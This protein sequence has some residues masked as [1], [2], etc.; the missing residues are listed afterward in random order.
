M[1]FRPYNTNQTKF[2]NLDYRKLLGEDSDAVII[3]NIV[4]VL[5]LSEFELKYVE[6]GNPAYNPRMMMKIIIYG[7]VKSYFGGRP[8]YNNFENDLGLRFLSNDDFPDYR[9]INLFRVNFREEI[10]D[11]FAQ[12]VMLCKELDMIGFENL[13]IDGQK[14]KANANVFQNKNLKSIRKEKERIEIQLKKLLENELDFRQ[15]NEN[16][17][18]ISKKRE[19]LKRRKRRLDIAAQLLIDAGAENDDE[20]RYNLTDPDSRIMTDKRGVKNPDYNAQNAVDDKFQVLTAVDVTDTPSDNEELF[21]MKEKSKE[22]AGRNHENTLAD[23]GYGNKVKFG[24]MEQD[25][26]TE[27]Y[28][29]DKTMYSSKKNPFSKWNFKKDP[30]RDDV[31]ICPEGKEMIYQRTSKDNKGLPYR[32]Y[33][34]MDCSNCE[35]RDKCLRTSKKGRLKKVVK[36]NRKIAIYPEDQYVKKMREKLETDEGKK[37]YQRRMS[38]VEPLHGDIQKNR[39]F[40]QFVLRGIEKVRVEYNLI[41]IAHN[42]RKIKIHAGKNLDGYLKNQANIA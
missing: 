35:M 13:S 14:I 23:A 11:I 27:Y 25:N 16:K 31:Y 42:I 22:N 2:V 5:D 1:K 4:E 28:V 10:A 24:E 7:Y 36:I 37:I 8:L 20:L 15:E 9:T 41:G 34:C 3:H 29:P 39:G 18:L 30:D 19:K 40:I 26:D 17:E 32:L 12:V 33:E 38:T 6:I 21:P